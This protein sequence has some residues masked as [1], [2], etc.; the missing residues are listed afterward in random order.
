MLEDK[1]GTNKTN[2]KK[3]NKNSY[4]CSMLIKMKITN[5][6]SQDFTHIPNIRAGLM[7]SACPRFVSVKC[8]NLLLF[9]SFTVA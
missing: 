8:E 5:S 7:L 9:L 3:Q 2:L 1:S 6:G 4:Y